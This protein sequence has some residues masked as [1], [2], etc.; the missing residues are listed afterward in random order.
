MLTK[1]ASVNTGDG[2][3]EGAQ[4][5][6]LCARQLREH[7]GRFCVL[8][9]GKKQLYSALS[10]SG[11]EYNFTYDDKG[12]LTRSEITARRKDRGRFSVLRYC[13]TQGTV[14]CVDKLSGLC[15]NFQG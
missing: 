4:G 15:Y 9:D 10:S 13:G 11:Q 3:V 6:V 12:N 8:T 2:S 14:L 5:T 7:R 1:G